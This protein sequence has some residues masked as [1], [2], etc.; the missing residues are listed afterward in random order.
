MPY[1]KA[2]YWHGV[3]GQR[4]IIYSERGL[5]TDFLIF[6][7]RLHII[8]R[9]FIP[10]MACVKVYLVGNDCKTAVP[11]QKVLDGR[12]IHANTAFEAEKGH[13]FRKG[14]VRRI[15][16]HGDHQTPPPLQKKKGIRL[17]C[18]TITASWCLCPGISG[19]RTGPAS[20]HEGS[21]SRPRSYTRAHSTPAASDDNPDERSFQ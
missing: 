8:L 7:V 4:E 21:V 16:R 2:A 6:T 20:G 15:F 12:A 18:P 10:E 9:I 11:H 19:A 14:I 13:R 17:N 1:T 3:K 5:M